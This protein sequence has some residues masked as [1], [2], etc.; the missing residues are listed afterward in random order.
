MPPP[1]AATADTNPHDPG[2]AHLA[3]IAVM[4]VFV[5]WQALFPLRHLLHPAPPEWYGRS[6]LFAW[7]MLTVDRVDAVRIRVE[8]PGAG[9]VGYVSLEEY[10]N[11]TQLER[12][13]R[14]PTSFLRFV[15]FLRAEM[16][17]N[18]GID[19]AR[20]FVDVKRQLNE[21]PFQQLI[22]PGRDL[23]KVPYRSFGD[24]DYVLPLDPSI[25]VG[26][27]DAISES[28]R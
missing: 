28:P 15:H 21:R 11:R 25:P 26:S 23:T 8:V 1:I 2:R 27:A 22:D 4:G 12:M 6:N 20:I 7:R 16:S 19:D 18:A 17:A 3:I 14:M 13:S 9:T 24:A 10:V 5:A